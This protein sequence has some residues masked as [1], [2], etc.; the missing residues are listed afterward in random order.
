MPPQVKGKYFMP[1]P[2]DIGLQKSW[3]GKKNSEKKVRKLIE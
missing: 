2:W 3:V 1:H